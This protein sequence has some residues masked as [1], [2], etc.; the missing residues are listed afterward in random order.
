MIQN[1]PK[2]TPNTDGTWIAARWFMFVHYFSFTTIILELF[3]YTTL[4]TVTVKSTFSIDLG[5][6]SCLTSLVLTKR[7]FSSILPQKRVNFW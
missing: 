6:F 2:I 4:Y 3:L 1:D 7:P 5:Q